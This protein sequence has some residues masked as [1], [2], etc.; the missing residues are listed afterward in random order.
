MKSRLEIR[1]DNKT[2]KNDKLPELSALEETYQISNQD[3]KSLLDITTNL[4]IPQT[5]S[6]ASFSKRL[7]NG[8]VVQLISDNPQSD[9]NIFVK[10]ILLNVVGGRRTSVVSQ[11][12]LEWLSTAPSRELFANYGKRL[13][14]ILVSASGGHQAWFSGYGKRSIADYL[15]KQKSHHQVIPHQSR[16]IQSHPFEY[17]PF[18]NHDSFINQYQQAK[19]H[20][21]DNVYKQRDL[22]FSATK[23]KRRSILPLD[24]SKIRSKISLLRHLHGTPVQI[25]KFLPSLKRSDRNDIHDQQSRVRDYV[26]RLERNFQTHQAWFAGYGKRNGKDTTGHQAWFGKKRV[27]KDLASHHTLLTG[28]HKRNDKQSPD[29]QAWF[30][31]YGK[32]PKPSFQTHQAWFAGYGKRGKSL[33]SGHQ[34]WSAGFG[35]RGTNVNSDHQAWFA[36]YGK[37]GKN[38]NP[39][40]QAWFAGYGKRGTNVNSDHQVW[41][42]GYGKRGGKLTSDHQ[43][44]FAGYGKRGSKLN[45]HH[46]AW[47]AGY[48]KRGNNVNSDHQA[49]FAGYGK[50]GEDVNSDHQAW[51]AGYGKRGKNINS[52]HQAW[53]AGY[54]KRGKKANSDHQAWFAGYGKR[55]KKLNSDH[56]A[57]FAGYGKRS[58]DYLKNQRI[59]SNLLNHSF[60]PSKYIDSSQDHFYSFKNHHRLEPNKTKSNLGRGMTVIP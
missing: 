23:R 51:F 10:R 8:H 50:R 16:T 55:G 15:S 46:Q 52:D 33:N 29:H 44:R 56:Q 40:H 26:K 7:R 39:S 45:S 9:D 14:D 3:L 35:K 1:D 53:F 22:R 30:A 4:Q 32:R 37:R 38:S 34:A 24:F 43:A 13:S 54:G 59:L 41:F 6:P 18:V 36:G 57:W 2:D 49:W 47:F 42:A 11:K 5:H 31:G 21:N 27:S 12:L 19:G 48:G 60:I 17:K 20:K 28:Y 25:D 58:I